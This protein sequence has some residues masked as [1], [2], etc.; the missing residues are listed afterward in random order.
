[1]SKRTTRALF[2]DY[3]HAPDPAGRTLIDT[4]VAIEAKSPN[5]ERYRRL[6]RNYRPNTTWL[7]D[8]HELADCLPAAYRCDLEGIR[9]LNMEIPGI[10]YEMPSIVAHLQS[11]SAVAFRSHGRDAT[12]ARIR[13]RAITCPVDPRRN[14]T[15][16]TRHTA[17]LIQFVAEDFCLVRAL[18]DRERKENGIEHAAAVKAITDTL[19]G[20]ASKYITAICRPGA[21]IN[22]IVCQRVGEIT[23]TGGRGE[24]TAWLKHNRRYW[25][26]IATDAREKASGIVL[27]Y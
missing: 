25:K 11:L 7:A 16:I 10:I 20:I 21:R 8:D 19:P 22:A 26:T 18:Y 2:M 13:I 14:S 6:C 4:L 12:R 24:K 27:H 9:T 5:G 15:P 1:M 3:W 23:G 17:R